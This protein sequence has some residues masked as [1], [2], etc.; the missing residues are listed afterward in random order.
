MGATVAME[1]RLASSSKR[2]YGVD[3]GLSGGVAAIE[4]TDR[5]ATAWAQPMPLSG[6]R[7]DWKTLAGLMT[8]QGL[9]SPP[10]LIVLEKCSAMPGQG[11]CSMFKFGGACEGVVATA[12]AL[13]HSVVEVTPQ[14]WKAE[15]LSGT[16]R[17]K[18]AAIEYC[19]LRWP[20]LSL[21]P[22]GCRKPRDGMADALCLAEYG[23]RIYARQVARNQPPKAEI[24]QEA[25]RLVRRATFEPARMPQDERSGPCPT[26]ESGRPAIGP[27]IEA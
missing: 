8:P 5:D 26:Q 10:S 15:I 13:G 19:R 6:R 20:G 22:K 9:G 14:K 12:L 21:I 18:E 23:R 1:A 4:I 7:V 17:D 11:V 24:G 16:K 3:P 27:Q 25:P 2:I